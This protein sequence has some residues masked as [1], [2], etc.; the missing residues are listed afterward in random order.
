MSEFRIGCWKLLVWKDNK[1]VAPFL[2]LFLQFDHSV[3]DWSNC[4]VDNQTTSIVAIS[5]ESLVSQHWLWI[6]QH[7]HFAVKRN[8]T[9]FVSKIVCIPTKMLHTAKEYF[10]W[11]RERTT[12]YCNFFNN[13]SATITCSSILGAVLELPARQH[14]QSS[15]FI[16][17][18]GQMGWIGRAVQLVAPN[19][20]ENWGCYFIGAATVWELLFK[21]RVSCDRQMWTCHQSLRFVVYCTGWKMF[22]GSKLLFKF[23]DTLFSGGE[24]KLDQWKIH[25]LL[26]RKYWKNQDFFLTFRYLMSCVSQH[27]TSF[28]TTNDSSKRSA[29]STKSN[30][31]S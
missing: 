16:M 30:S 15:P 6:Q 2:R 12:K 28:I 7:V 22:W 3:C 27:R 14:C 17:K 13:G 29:N 10:Y 24:N 19:Q 5:S 23:R 8:V 31:F 1:N 9:Y 11:S 20:K 25:S 21:L 26:L 18:M 4:I